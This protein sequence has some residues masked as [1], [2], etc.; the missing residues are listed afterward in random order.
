MAKKKV[1]TVKIIKTET[2]PQDTSGG[3]PNPGGPGHGN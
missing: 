1:K 3:N 2:T